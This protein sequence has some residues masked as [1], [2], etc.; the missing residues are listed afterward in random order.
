MNDTK[1]KPSRPF[2]FRIPYKEKLEE[3]FSSFTFS[4][5]ALFLVLLFGMTLS[6]GATLLKLN[7]FILVETPAKGGTLVEGILGSPRFINPLLAISD[8]DRDL[9][10]LVYSG[11]MK[12][13]PEGN[14]TL[15]LA[16]E[17]KISED[18]L[19]Y[20]FIIKEG[21][22]FHDGTRVT[23]E[24]IE[25]TVLRAQDPALKS[26]KRANW[27]SVR[28]EIV[29][30]KEI[31]FILNQPYSPFLENATIGILPKHLWK[32]VSSEEFP[33]SFLNVE[34][35]GSGPFKLS[36]ITRN[37]SGIPERFILTS[38]REYSLG[39]PYLDRIILMF[40]PNEQELIEA[41]VSGKI[42][43]INSIT[44]GRM[45]GLSKENTDIHSV[46]L[47]RVFGVFFNQNQSN[48][49][50]SEPVREALNLS[51]DKKRIIDEVL[52]GFGVEA[53]S[54]I[55]ETLRKIIGSN[56]ILETNSLSEDRI[57]AS[58]EIL[59]DAGWKIGEDGVYKKTDSKTKSV[60]R[61]EFSLTTSNAP[62]LKR[63]AEII[64][65]TWELLGA[66]VN[67]QI[68]EPGDLSQNVIRPRKY[69]ALLFGEIIGRD[70]DLFAFWHSS[71][72]NDP[73]LNIALYTNVSVDKLLSEARGANDQDLRFQKYREFEEEVLKETPAVFVY[74]PNFIYITPSKIDGLR[75]GH[76]TIPSDRFLNVSEWYV[77]TEKVWKFFTD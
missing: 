35:I 4:E 42:E 41:W 25:F 68:F 31:S 5:K 44:P 12:N 63:T 71:Q 70:L 13:D 72:R 67:I 47:S 2:Y 24:D 59:E 3:A 49:F 1:E 17:Y 14:I 65:E 19:V 62:E 56:T 6:A 73:G 37:S 55:P 53:N 77:N 11:L 7:D 29:S 58:K 57:L 39:S 20:T 33:L 10:S 22:K 9:T 61:L 46:P 21:A 52:F 60:E 50:I 66:R 28:V 18:G 64:K 23:A 16:E 32:N 34:P 51:L 54:P 26:S 40:Y 15:D 38:F 69:D 45:F 8:A 76:I 36:S 74:S 27:D 30:E 48:L 43:S 75:F